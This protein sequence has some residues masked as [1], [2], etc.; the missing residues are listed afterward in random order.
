MVALTLIDYPSK[1]LSQAHFFLLESNPAC[2]S[3]DK[4]NIPL[5]PLKPPIKLPEPFI[6]ERHEDFSISQF[7]TRCANFPSENCK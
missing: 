4:K 5:S 7:I 2:Q 3:T 1:T 6:E